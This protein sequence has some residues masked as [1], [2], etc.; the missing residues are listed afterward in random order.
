MVCSYYSYCIDLPVA[1]IDCKVEVCPLH[2]YQICQGEYVVLNDI[3]FDEADR[4][5]CHNCINELRGGGKS[6]KLNKVGD[7]TMY[8][9]EKTDE[10][11]E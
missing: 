9:M 8:G 1:L 7:S 4:K 2:L 10:D 5:I 6:E 3:D 11:E